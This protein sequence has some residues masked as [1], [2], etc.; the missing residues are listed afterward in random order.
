MAWTVIPAQPGFDLVE[1]TFVDE[2]KIVNEDY[3]PRKVT[4]LATTP[5]VAWV[6]AYKPETT[7]G[8][9]GQRAW[10]RPVTCSADDPF[11]Y[12][13]RHNGITR[14]DNGEC[15]TPGQDDEK[16][17]AFFQEME[18]QICADIN[19]DRRRAALIKDMSKPSE[20]LH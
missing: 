14:N 2:K 12:A 5:I 17:I 11:Q 6:V 8:E 10:A 1:P 20:P 15:F 18:D 4:G 13:I 3:I 9:G 19:E 7:S 16:L